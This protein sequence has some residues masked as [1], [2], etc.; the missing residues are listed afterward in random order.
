MTLDETVHVIRLETETE[1]SDAIEPE[2]MFGANPDPKQPI[3]AQVS[4]GG[5]LHRG[6]GPTRDA[7]ALELLNRL[8][9][10]KMDGGRPFRTGLSGLA[11]DVMPSGQRIRR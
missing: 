4:Y 7:A 2:R 6:F 11:G 8:R 3:A 5:V 10:W 9:Q 1:A